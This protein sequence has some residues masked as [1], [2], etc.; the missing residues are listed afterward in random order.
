M[1]WSALVKGLQQKFLDARLRLN[2]MLMANNVTTA[3]Q[4]WQQQY[5]PIREEINKDQDAYEARIAFA[6][7][8]KAY[9]AF[10]EIRSHYVGKIGQVHTFAIASKHEEAK[11]ALVDTRDEFL[12]MQ[13]LLQKIVDINQTAINKDV[14]KAQSIFTQAF[15]IS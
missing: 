8:R 12:Q 10:K 11:A 9:N 4:I 5:L 15:Y 14:V 7:T 3:E 2:M 1:S 6:E 13:A